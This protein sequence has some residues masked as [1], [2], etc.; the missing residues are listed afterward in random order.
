[1]AYKEWKLNLK[2]LGKPMN[3]KILKEKD[4]ALMWKISGDQGDKKEQARIIKEIK[5]RRK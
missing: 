2:D 5:K 4:L 1:M 3:L